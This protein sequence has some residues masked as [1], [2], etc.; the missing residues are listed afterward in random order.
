MSSW[1]LF[2]SKPSDEAMEG[3]T[4]GAVGRR[5]IG[6]RDATAVECREGA[7][8][9]TR[10]ERGCPR[11]RPALLSLS[12]MPA[13]YSSTAFLSFWH[14]QSFCDKSKDSELTLIHSGRLAPQPK[15]VSVRRLHVWHVLPSRCS[16][17][18]YSVTMIS[19]VECLCQHNEPFGANDMSYD[20]MVNRCV[21]IPNS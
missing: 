21:S 7:V 8:R 18:F 16:S 19:W 5:W 12:L 3:A 15:Q 11:M 2:G 10:L 1:L 4:S 13:L 9:L 6:G 20:R 17:H 14:I